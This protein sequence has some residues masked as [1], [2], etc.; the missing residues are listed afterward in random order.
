M[1]YPGIDPHNTFDFIMSASEQYRLKS[2]FYFKGGFSNKQFDESYNLDA[3]WLEELMRN[4]HARG[5][6]IGL[7]GSYESYRDPI[8]LRSE[9]ASLLKA[10]E[11]VKITQKIWGGRQHYL[12]WENP[13]TWQIWEDAGLDYDA[14]LGFA[15]HAGFRCGTCHEFPV[16]NLRTRKMLRLR[17]RPLIAMDTTLEKYMALSPR[18]ILEKICYLSGVCRRYG[19]SLTLLWHNTSLMSESQKQLYLK[20]L[21]MVAK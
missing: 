4:I 15:D 11:R 13:T 10:V 18:E 20:V 1:L 16:F 7:H 5:H 19:G 17:E 6:E 9:F 12:R 8:K 21:E 3:P 2:A 14:T